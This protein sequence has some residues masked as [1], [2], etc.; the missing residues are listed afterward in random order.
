MDCLILVYRCVYNTDVYISQY[1]DNKLYSS[2]NS[3]RKLILEC[4]IN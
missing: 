2:A 1:I 4:F 3:H